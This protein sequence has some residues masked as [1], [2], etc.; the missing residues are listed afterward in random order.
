[1]NYRLWALT[2]GNFAVGTG[3][4]IVAGILPSI[5]SSLST[6]VA[7]AGQLV[8]IYGLAL[9]I[10]APLL[11]IAT[12]HIDR[13]PLMLGGLG[14]FVLACLVGAF[15]ANFTVLALSRALAGVGAA[16][17]TP[18]AAVLAAHLARPEQRGRAIS[19]VFAGFSLASVIGAPLGT[20]IGSSFGW[21]SA[22]A[23]VAALG[24]LAIILLVKTSLR[25]PQVPLVPAR[26]WFRLFR[27]PQP[28]LTV[29]TTVLSMAGQYS[30]F[31]YIAA[32]LARSHGIGPNGLSALLI[33]FGIAGVA[34]NAATGKWVDRAGAD[35]V[36]TAGI[37]ILLIAFMLLAFSAAS[38]A[39]TAL[40]LGLWGG[41]AFS[42]GTAQQARLVKQDSRLASATLAMNTSAL[43]V[44]QAGGAV[45]G[46]IAISFFGFDCVVWT[47]VML[48]VA[49]LATSIWESFLPPRNKE[50]ERSRNMPSAS[51][52]R[53]G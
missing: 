22:F 51:A 18:N 42:V 48:L 4:L 14:V 26:T 1:M 37:G 3:S 8:T 40:A 16:L 13:R 17:F 11:G 53:T 31:T 15:A 25:D 39:F 7:A 19:L 50:N 28:M 9:A 49:A 44:G 23:L 27:Q 12:R 21:R 47:G 30:L 35:R 36:A 5:A 20:F 32:L 41:A 34:G 38:L 33:W 6:S 52:P 2:L 43:Y 29:M 46:G 45:L 24:L 10:G